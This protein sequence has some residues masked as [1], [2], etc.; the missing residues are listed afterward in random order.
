MFN[1]FRRAKFHF[2][3]AHYGIVIILKKEKEHNVDILHV[4][5]KFH[6]FFLSWKGV[7]SRES[8]NE[9]LRSLAKE[10]PVSLLILYFIFPQ[11]I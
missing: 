1:K 8:G 3:I 11:C 5:A 9:G 2:I 4:N 7:V 10:L 6:F